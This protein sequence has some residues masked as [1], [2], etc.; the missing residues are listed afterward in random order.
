MKEPYGI[1]CEENK[2]HLYNYETQEAVKTFLMKNKIPSD[3]CIR[4]A[5]GQ[6]IDLEK[7][8]DE[9]NSLEKQVFLKIMEDGDGKYFTKTGNL[10]R[11][12]EINE[13]LKYEAER[14]GSNYANSLAHNARYKVYKNLKENISKTAIVV[15]GAGIIGSELIRQLRNYPWAALYLW[16]EESVTER[17]VCYGSFYN[18]EDLGKSRTE[19]LSSKNLQVNVLKKLSDMGQLQKD[20]PYIHVIYTAEEPDVVQMRE[21]NNY[22]LNN[23]IS[24]SL[25]TADSE[26]LI[27]GP[28]LYPGQTGCL[29]CNLDMEHLQNKYNLMP[30]EV[31]LLIGMFMS[32][33]GKITGVMQEFIVEDIA[34]TIG[35]AF[36]INRR[37]MEGTSMDVERHLD[38]EVC[39]PVKKSVVYVSKTVDDDK[40]VV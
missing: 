6:I 14:I 19:T 32:D 29:C 5:L 25:L 21:I 7:L 27:I 34:V 2:V 15:C 22:M 35:R 20:Y 40:A 10:I 31:N 26:R 18:K 4:L 39:G 24:W 30:Y 36:F 3:F 33:I 37:T 23:K 28:T 38:C 13:I 8:T 1:V 16:D 11:E 9:M 17:D 12:N